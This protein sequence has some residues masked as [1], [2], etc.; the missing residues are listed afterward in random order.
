M[1]KDFLNRLTFAT[2]RSINQTLFLLTLLDNDILKLIELEDFP[3]IKLE[4]SMFVCEQ[5][6]K[7]SSPWVEVEI[8]NGWQYVLIFNRF[9]N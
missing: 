5:D 1:N 3:N 8:F 4:E 2:N 6:E 7:F 9:N